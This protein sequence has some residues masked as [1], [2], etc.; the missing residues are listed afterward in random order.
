MK[1]IIAGV[2]ALSGLIAIAILSLPW[3]ISTSQIEN[4]I[5]MRFTQFTGLTLSYANTA[6]ATFYPWPQLEIDNVAINHPA[7]PEVPL[8]HIASIKIQIPLLSMILGDWE[9]SEFELVRPDFNFVYLADGGTNW[10]ARHHQENKRAAKDREPITKANG[11]ATQEI[12]TAIDKIKQIR[13]VDAIITV[14][15]RESGITRRL[16]NIHALLYQAQLSDQINANGK[17]VW[18]GEPIEFVASANQPKALLEGENSEISLEIKSSPLQ[19][20]YNGKLALGKSF[21][22][23]GETSLSTPSLTR[24]A[25]LLDLGSTTPAFPTQIAVTGLVKSKASLLVFEDAKLNIDGNP[26]TGLL[27]FD[28]G[29]DIPRLSGTLAFETLALPSLDHL[30]GEQIPLQKPAT[31]QTQPNQSTDPLNPDVDVRFSAEQLTLPN[32]TLKNVAATFVS[33]PSDWK[34]DIGEAVLHDGVLV[35]SLNAAPGEKENQIHLKGRLKGAN[36]KSLSEVFFDGKLRPSGT[37][38]LEFELN[39]GAQPGLLTGANLNGKFSVQAD[40]AV[41]NGVDLFQAAKTLEKNNGFLFAPDLAGETDLSALNLNFIVLN[42]VGWI[43]EGRAGAQE[44]RI[45]TTGKID[46]RQGGLALTAALSTKTDDKP[47]LYRMF[48][49]GTLKNPLITDYPTLQ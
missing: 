5:N 13:L 37:G 21:T 1:R 46:F 34:L 36:L 26:S 4:Q 20:S 18:Q 29:R 40:S 30:V 25:K 33:S 11:V 16:T 24:L 2:L 31:T 39:S 47:V 23:E 3:W 19:F 15:N 41:L 35:A 17:L 8:A 7:T 28:L 45:K 44:G 27:Q 42:G 12:Q 43:N 10:G 9:P 48:I 14:E 38:D 22:A 49:G 6:T 32:L